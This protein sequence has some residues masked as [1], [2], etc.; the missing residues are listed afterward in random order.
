MRSLRCVSTNWSMCVR[1]STLCVC[2]WRMALATRQLATC[3]SWFCPFSNTRRWILCFGGCNVV[4][5]ID[6][7]FPGFE[8]ILVNF[9]TINS[10]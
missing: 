6:T 7:C 4:Q 8:F 10:K 1:V 5:D 3:R 2:D 9:V